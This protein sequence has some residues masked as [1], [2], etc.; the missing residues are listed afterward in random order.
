MKAWSPDM[1]LVA[2]RYG[3]AEPCG[4]E[5]VRTGDIDLVLVPLVGWDR[6]GGRLG[7]GAGF[8]DRLFRPYAKLEKPLRIGVAY[9]LQGLPGVP[10][11]P[12]D[13]PLHGLLTENGWFTCEGAGATKGPGVLE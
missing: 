10:R 2:N 9:D 7:M 3:I 12:W 6:A 4:T 5:D 11:D 1:K 8:Y 13:I